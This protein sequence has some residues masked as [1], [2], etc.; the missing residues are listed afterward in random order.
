MVTAV[1]VVYQTP[2]RQ[3]LYNGYSN[4]C[5]ILDTMQVASLQWLQQFLQYTRHHAGSFFT[6]VT[7]IPVVYQTPCRQLLYNGYSNSCSILDTMQVASL[8]WLQQ[9]LQYT[10]Q[11]AGSFFTM[12]TAVPEVHQTPCRQLLYNGYSN[13]CSILDTMQVASLQ[14]LQQFL[15]YTRH[16]AGSFFTMVTAVPEVHQTT[17]RQ[18]LYNGYSNSCSILDTMQVAS[19]QWLQQFLQYTRHHAGSF[20]TMVTAVPL[21]HQTPCRQLLYN[22]Y[23]SSCSTLDTMQVASLQWLQQFLQYTR[24]HA[25]SFFTMVTAVPVVYQTPC[26]QLLY[27]GYSSSF[28]I[29]DNMQVAS[30]Q[31]LQQFLQYTRQHAGSFI[32]MATAI[33]VVYQTPCRQLLYNGYSSSCSI[34]DTMQVAS[35]QWLQQFLQYTRCHA[36]SFITMVT[37]VPVVYQTP[38]RQLLYNSY[39]SSCSILDTMQVA[40]LQWLQQFLQYTR[41]HAGSFLTMATA[42]PVVYQTPCRQLHYNGYSNSCSILDTMQVAYLEWL[43]QFLQYTRH[44]AGSFITM[45]TAIPVIYQTPCRQLLYNG[46]SSSCSTLD[47]MQ[48]ASLQWLQQFLEYTRHHAGSFFTMVTAVPVVYQTPCRQLLYNGYSSSCSI[49]DT[50]QVAS[51]Q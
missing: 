36:G 5:S 11:H 47:T 35:L 8:Q 39:S 17:C 50:M 27:N 32:T 51:L 20:F 13:S 19:L 44:H 37:A 38:C 34:L 24:H 22:G 7:A 25:G 40:S 16:H 43:Q 31:W 29:L 30:L 15:Q 48:V 2:C 14:W 49:L 6:M 33:P 41:H 12:V 10:R 4:S 23:S 21:V 3:L 42:I 46:Y 26:R 28:S 18:L 45:A 9:F 1:P